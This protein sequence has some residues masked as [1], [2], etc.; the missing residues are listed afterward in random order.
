ME[1]QTYYNTPKFSL[2]NKIYEAN[3]T[4]PEPSFLLLSE[5]LLNQN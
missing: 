3:S 1:K 4:R 5:T 2:K